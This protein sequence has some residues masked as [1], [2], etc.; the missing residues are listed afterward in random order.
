MAIG[1][2]AGAV[3]SDELGK[4]QGGTLDGLTNAVPTVLVVA[5]LFLAQAVDGAYG[6]LGRPLP[7][8]FAPLTSACVGM[9]VVAWFHGFSRR[10]RIPW[11]VDM[12]WFLL[13]AWIII[14]PYYLLRAEGKRGVGRIGLF[15]LTY[16]AAWA[17]GTAIRIWL[18]VATRT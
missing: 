11:V 18:L 16:F 3:A 10:Q 5:S 17:T 2:A 15:C 6:G 8:A 1:M 4:R 7:P 9:S 12:G 13:V 14:V